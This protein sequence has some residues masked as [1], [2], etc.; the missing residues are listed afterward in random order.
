MKGLVCLASAFLFYTLPVVAYERFVTR[1]ELPSGAHLMVGDCTSDRFVTKIKLPSGKTA[2]I[3][4]GDF[5]ARS[6]GSF[7]IR[8]YEAAVSAVNE[9]AYFIGGLVQARDGSVEDVLLDDIDGVGQAEIVVTV[10]SAG[11]GAYLSA[12]AFTVSL[13]GQLALVGNVEYLPPD[14]D[15]VA[16]LRRAR[17]GGPDN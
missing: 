13:E 16:A 7:S 4:E 3:S 15:P 14:A 6:I 12:H 1:M 10:R 11:S 9:T 5:E 2:V 8:V 17:R